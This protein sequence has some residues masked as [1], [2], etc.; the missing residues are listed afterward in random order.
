M[1]RALL[2]QQVYKGSPYTE[3]I[4]LT[5]ARNL[6]YCLRFDM[7]YL[8][9]YGNVVEEWEVRFG[10]WAK[11]V[12]ILKALQD[13][14]KHVVWLDADALIAD[15]SVDLRCGC[16]ELGVGVALHKPK[17]QLTCNVGVMY[18]TNSAETQD[19]LKMWL[20]WF[21]GPLNGWHENAMLNLFT[22]IP[23]YR[24]FIARIED[25]WNSCRAADNHVEN[26]VIE[27]FHGEG[28]PA[29]RIQLMKEWLHDHPL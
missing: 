1:T 3:A 15:T 9:Q 16:P 4:K 17:G 27:G 23:E 11:I 22:Q 13:D 28:E 21:P 14:Y 8:V 24:P 6:D 29:R 19:F 12:M 18:V 5:Y 2:L 7:D 25:K 20:S 10:G 26:A